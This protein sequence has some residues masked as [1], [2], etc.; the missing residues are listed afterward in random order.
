MFVF[1]SDK[2][3]L[4]DDDHLMINFGEI[5]YEREWLEQTAQ[6]LTRVDKKRDKILIKRRDSLNLV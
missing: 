2:A 3:E 1:C 4:I 6:T 5:Y